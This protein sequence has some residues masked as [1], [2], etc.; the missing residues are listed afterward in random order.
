MD[1]IAK[2]L[3]SAEK[4]L[5][6]LKKEGDTVWSI[7]STDDDV[8]LSNGRNDVCSALSGD[9]R[10]VYRQTHGRMVVARHPIK[11]GSIENFRQKANF[12]F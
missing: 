7:Y 12:A 5:S 3:E 6:K 4:E 11:Q 10:L 9:T 2:R 1:K 8:E